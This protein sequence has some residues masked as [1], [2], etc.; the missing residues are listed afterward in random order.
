[1]LSLLALYIA[2]Y[3]LYNSHY[4]SLQDLTS[5]IAYQNLIIGAIAKEQSL[6][7]NLQ[8]IAKGVS[9][10]TVPRFTKIYSDNINFLESIKLQGSAPYQVSVSLGSA[11]QTFLTD[12]FILSFINSAIA[13][14]GNMSQARN[15]AELIATFAA[16]SPSTLQYLLTNSQQVK[17]VMM[18]AASVREGEIG[19]RIVGFM[20]V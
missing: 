19:K 5:E 16:A 15:T 17:E 20:Q 7:N 6:L 4:S 2:F 14:Y 13:V 9:P 1:M 10:D 3:F 11:N 12:E 8:L 18:A